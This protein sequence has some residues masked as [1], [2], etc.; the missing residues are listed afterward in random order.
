MGLSP[1]AS[2]LSDMSTPP[3]TPLTGTAGHSRAAFD[4]RHWAAFGLAVLS[5]VLHLYVGVLAE[6]GFAPAFYLAGVGWLV[7]AAVFLTPYWRRWMYLVAGVYAVVQIGLWV[8]SGFQFLEVGVVDK[9]AEL[10]L[11]VLVVVLYREG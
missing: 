10:A 11:L 2:S 3:E 7:G 6:P 8:A 5:G 4:R 9:L 1:P